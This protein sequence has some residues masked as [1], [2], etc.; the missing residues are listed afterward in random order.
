MPAGS[1]ACT[2]ASDGA[3]RSGW[4]PIAPY[5]RAALLEQREQRRLGHRTLAQANPDERVVHVALVR[6]EFR[7]ERDRLQVRANRFDRRDCALERGARARQIALRF[8]QQ[9][10]AVERLPL[11][12]DEAR[13]NRRVERALQIAP[14]VVNPAHAPQDFAA[15]EQRL[16]LAA[17][18]LRQPGER[19]GVVERVERVFV[20]VLVER[21]DDADVAPRADLAVAVGG[22][23]EQLLRAPVELEGFHRVAETARQRAAVHQQLRLFGRLHGFTGSE[24]AVEI[25]RALVGAEALVQR[26]E[27]RQR[28]LAQPRARSLGADP[29][30]RRDCLL[31]HRQ[32]VRVSALQ[33]VD[34]ADIVQPL[35]RAVFRSRLLVERE[36]ATERRERGVV[37]AEILLSEA[38]GVL[39][40][41][42]LRDRSAAQVQIVGL[43]R[44]AHRAL[45]IA[46]RDRC[47]GGYGQR[48][49]IRLHTAAQGHRETYNRN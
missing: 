45:V 44:E 17:A 48:V 49:C 4:Q 33:K 21:V 11:F 16:R 31:I 25:E 6:E 12:L 35:D 32:R 41:R 8:R 10:E 2:A 26:G 13:R 24:L 29:I 9:A 5:A 19:Q 47:F 7:S 18:V 14:R 40:P 39:I 15:V 46:L 20:I 3:L 42:G 38:D 22:V 37:A 1:A 23:G 43:P 36:R 27:V 34:G 30:D 28:H